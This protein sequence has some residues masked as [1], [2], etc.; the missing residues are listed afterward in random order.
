MLIFRL[1]TRLKFGLAASSLCIVAAV[2]ALIA[3]SENGKS[4]REP[5]RLDLSG[6]KLTFDENF[7]NLDV[8]A[9]GPGT[10]WI[11]HTPWNGDF[12]DAQFVA[13]SPGFPFTIE[14][15]AL[16]IEARR[17]TDGK[18]R[19][20]LLASNDPKGN[21]FSQTF[22]YFEMR[23]KLP[24]GPGLWPAFW[25]VAN[26]DPDT[27]AEIDIV[28]HYG[29]FP[30]M[31]ESVVHV[32]KKTPLGRDYQ[33][34][35]RHQVPTGSLYEDYHLF[36]ASVEADYTVFYLDREEVGRSPTPPEH[37]H[38]MFILLNLAMGG[39]WPIDETPNPSFMW[40]DY[41]RAYQKLPKQ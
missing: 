20:G 7:E 25:L 5:D 17:G 12:G 3:S 26:K 41:V 38:A 10:R 4:L 23:A 27:S 40:V 37:R 19:S 9:W 28:E 21:G 36:G 16:R 24:K 33:A 14:N 15:G 2:V 11:A 18:W 34:L 32:W 30:D 31:Y 6:Y 35:L 29:K 22:G 8:S 39:G 1:L 13:P